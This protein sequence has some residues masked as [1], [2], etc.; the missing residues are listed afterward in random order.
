MVVDVAQIDT[1]RRRSAICAGLTQM[2]ATVSPRGIPEVHL[3]HSAT[4]I[5]RQ[6]SE[7]TSG[8][9]EIDV[10]ILLHAPRGMAGHALRDVEG[11]GRFHLEFDDSAESCL[12]LE[13]PFC[14]SAGGEAEEFVPPHAEWVRGVLLSLVGVR[15]ESARYGR[16]SGLRIKFADGRELFVP[17]GPF[18]NWHYS[19]STGT[20]LHGGV[21]RAG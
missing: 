14:L 10:Q 13:G 21:G 2:V 17:D 16:N 9:R 20:R 18:E 1:L 12:F 3:G 15:V 8:N 5:A 7:Q 11:D 19:N 6:R 4:T